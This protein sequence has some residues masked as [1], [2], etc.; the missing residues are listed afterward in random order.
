MKQIKK[1]LLLF[2]I[3]MISLNSIFFLADHIYNLD[4]INLTDEDE[5]ENKLLEIHPSDSS[6]PNK[7]NFTH[8]KII[9]LNH[10]KVSGLNNLT[11]FP[12]LISIFDTDLHDDVQSDGNDIAFANDTLWLDHEIELFNQ[13]FNS[14]HAQLIAW[15]RIPLLTVSV[16]TNITMY[17]GNPY[18]LSQ[19]NPTGVWDDN[20]KGVWHMK[21]VN[22]IDSTSNNNDG[23]QEG[24]V[25][26]LEGKIAGSNY[27][28]GIN[29]LI[30][31][32][33]VGSGIKTIEF[34]MNPS[35]LG[36]LDTIT[37]T[38]W[39]NPSAAGDYYDD[40]N[41]PIYAFTSND[42][43]SIGGPTEYQ[44]WY[45]F[46]FNIP[47][48]ATINGIQI[49]IEASYSNPVTGSVALS[50][51]GGNTYTS[52][53]IKSWND[54]G[55]NNETF[56]GSPTEVWGR[57]WSSEELNNNNFRV[58]IQRS[59]QATGTL[60]VD[61][62]SVKVYYNYE[63]MRII[64]LDGIS[65]IEIVEGQLLT[66][67]FPGIQTIYIDG[68]VD[69]SLTAD[70]HYFVI[71][72]S[73]GLD[74]SA[75]KI[76]KVSS[77]FFEG[78]IDELRVSNFSRTPDSFNTSYFNQNDPTSFY[79]ISQEISFN[80]DPPIY[81]NLTES[82]NILE[83]GDTEII[84]INATDPS[85]IR[86]VLIE[87]E[88]GN[89]SMTNIGGDIWSYTLWTPSQTDNYS[90]TIYIEDNCGI[91]NSVNNSIIVIDTTSPTYSNLI[92]SID[93]LELGDT[94]TISID[95]ND[96]SDISRVLIEF[97][98][99]NHSMVNIDGDTWLYNLWVPSHTG[100][101]NY[102]IYIEDNNNH[103]SSIIYNLTVQDT[104]PPLPPVIIN[105]PSGSNND[106]LTFDWEDGF[107]LSGIS[108]YI[109]IIDNESNPFTTP[110]FIAYINITNTGPES[111]YYELSDNLS[112]GTYYYLLSQIDGEGQ[113]NN[114]ISG[115]FAI[116]NGN[117]GGNNFTILDILPYILASVIGSAIVIVVVRKRI[118]SR[119]HPKRKKILLKT[120]TSHINKISSAKPI[121]E[122]GEQEKETDGVVLSKK[123][124]FNGKDLEK[125]LPEI[126]K[127]GEE[128]FEEGAYLEAQK[129]FEQA[130]VILLK[131]GKNE[132]ATY[133]Y[134]KILE[135]DELNEKREKKLEILEQEKL[136]NHA[137]N[138]TDLYFDLMDI[139]KKL[140]DFDSIEMYQSELI[141][142]YD[143]GILTISDFKQKRDKLEEEANSLLSQ[144]HFQKAANQYENC[145]EISHF[146]VKLGREEE[147][148]SVEKYK[149][150]KKEC[151]RKSQY[152][153]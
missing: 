94:I 114:F 145:E 107:D 122:R 40:W 1:I 120:I 45:N 110:G 117:G 119:L 133:Y 44:D 63:F 127:L 64:D 68:V 77:D 100:N 9:T 142:L 90:Y 141:Q 2:S 39:K 66:T 37:E 152:K 124:K 81:S 137:V 105:V 134:K 135:I 99:T 20:Y 55:D 46:T 98:E 121:L 19:E 42:S 52:S 88:G 79:N 12:V 95:A 126:K 129:Q 143:D 87:F 115:S 47:H 112:S 136:A 34:W 80:T 23:T 148:I 14:S 93:P 153:L 106:T 25:S 102:T 58:R 50:W 139:A 150:R 8:Y 41:N 26:N 43:Y 111:S 5:L 83:L 51:D 21:E 104:M 75:M 57:T 144:Q 118:Q 11:N 97:E 33:N 149:K 59:S 18:I 72:N 48:G 113:Q 128:L 30:T 103:S 91:W 140:K 108:Y 146:L 73:L 6:L 85:G 17:Y 84:S 24:G 70:W 132:K 101:Y 60:A 61:C 35:N 53:E 65:R 69:S 71:T 15:V 56:V 74:V 29:D 22:T 123:E 116:T 62:I 76:G 10:T 7:Y 32:G 130:E 151:I 138:I 4:G 86:Q 3:F 96:L 82:A 131:L 92:E 13:D 36:S 28:E 89:Y 16:D 38:S 31:I 67:N 27:F 78:K 49:E 54:A 109:L 147:I 125:L